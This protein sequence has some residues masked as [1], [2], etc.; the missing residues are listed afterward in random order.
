MIAH[1]EFESDVVLVAK[2]LL[3]GRLAVRGCEGRIS[4]VEAYHQSE[5]GCHGYRGITPSCEA[6]FGPAGRL[7][8]Y[9]CY[10][11]HMMLNIV[12]EPE[13]I[14]AAVLIRSLEPLLG[15]GVMRE[16]RGHVDDSLLC[17]GPGRL[18]QALGISSADNGACLGAGGISVILGAP[19]PS[20][21]LSAPRVGLSRG[22]DLP[23]R[24]ALKGE[25][26]LSRPMG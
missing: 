24:F 3:G 8:V 1:R 16:R 19:D 23:M 10:G 5:P 13:G 22:V 2:S 14:G 6:M 15:L 21:I 11:I 20:Q 7:Y 4:E 9:R 26:W 17:A 25:E 12:C 18:A